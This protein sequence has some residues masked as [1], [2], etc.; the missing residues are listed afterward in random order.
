MSVS[1]FYVG[2]NT[3]LEFFN[4]ETFRV[5]HDCWC[6]SLI[7]SDGNR[8][9]QITIVVVNIAIVISNAKF[10]SFT[11]MRLYSLVFIAAVIEYI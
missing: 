6:I 8:Y 10:C 9:Y 3:S 1:S 11:V 4:Q 2:M 7:H 5:G